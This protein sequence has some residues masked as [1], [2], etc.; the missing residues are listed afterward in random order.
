MKKSLATGLH[1]EISFGY[2]F[3]TESPI[4]FSILSPKKVCV[5]AAFFQCQNFHLCFYQLSITVLP[6]TTPLDIRQFQGLMVYI[7][8][9]RHQSSPSRWCHD[10]VI[11]ISEERR[12]LLWALG[13]I[14]TPVTK[15]LCCCQAAKRGGGTLDHY[16]F[17]NIVYISL[18][19]R[20]YGYKMPFTI[21]AP[22]VAYV[23]TQPWFSRLQPSSASQE[24]TQFY[25]V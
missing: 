11:I 2:R 1:L 18:F 3:L 21:G 16:I 7:R 22:P 9:W 25:C 12:I 19:S 24:K 4:F 6:A 20:L 15:R 5:D 10:A 13:T 17:R 8:S 14:Q 23:S